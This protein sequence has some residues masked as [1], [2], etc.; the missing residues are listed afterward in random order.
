MNFNICAQDSNVGMTVIVDKVGFPKVPYMLHD[1]K[2]ENYLKYA[3]KEKGYQIKK[4]NYL[5]TSHCYFPVISLLF[6][7]LIGLVA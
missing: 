4:L 2:S 5:S 7:M 3:M 6:T 1:L